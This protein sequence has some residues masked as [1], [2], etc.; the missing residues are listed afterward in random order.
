MQSS[1]GALALPV[2]GG[3]LGT[4]EGGKKDGPNGNRVILCFF[5]FNRFE[6]RHDDLFYRGSILANLLPVE[7][8]TK[9]GFLSILSLSQTAT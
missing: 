6:L 4:W 9:T 1:V 2:S 7:V 8:V 5:V 3:D